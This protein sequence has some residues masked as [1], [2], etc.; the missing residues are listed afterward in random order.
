MRTY[1]RKNHE[2]KTTPK[3]PLC[4]EMKNVGVWPNGH[5]FWVLTCPKSQKR[6]SQKWVFPQIQISFPIHFPSPCNNYFNQFLAELNDW[7]NETRK[8]VDCLMG[9]PFDIWIFPI[10]PKG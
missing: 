10:G 5:A 2:G 4:E 7:M 8:V 1:N 9:S 3:I 6:F